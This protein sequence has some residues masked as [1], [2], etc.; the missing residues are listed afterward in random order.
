MS[1]IKSTKTLAIVAI[2]VVV[3]FGG[4]AT[5]SMG[6]AFAQLHRQQVW[7]NSRQWEQIV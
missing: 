4:V 6:L 3:A 2:A 1:I 5:N 7:L